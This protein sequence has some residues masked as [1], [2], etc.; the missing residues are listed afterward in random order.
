[1]AEGNSA[2]F[3]NS[4][5]PLAEINEYQY[6]ALVDYDEQDSEDDITDGMLAKKA[7]VEAATRVKPSLKLPQGFH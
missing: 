3:S 5:S 7:R 6:E 1:M 2:T 4:D